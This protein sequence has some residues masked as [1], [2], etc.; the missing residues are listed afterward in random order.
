[1]Q[2]KHSAKTEK[3]F[4]RFFVLSVSRITGNFSSAHILLGRKI[5]FTRLQLSVARVIYT[6]AIRLSA[7]FYI[8]FRPLAL[9]S[10]HVLAA[11]YFVICAGAESYIFAR[12]CA[13]SL[14]PAMYLFKANSNFRN[15]SG[16][17]NYIVILISCFITN[18]YISTHSLARSLARPLSLSFV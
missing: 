2:Y 1:M 14:T 7:H 18:V 12:I 4:R 8:F 17:Y 13:N 11:A 10:A 3:G 5:K 9:P 6:A 16:I 15:G